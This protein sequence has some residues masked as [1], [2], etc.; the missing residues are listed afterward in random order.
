MLLFIEEI[1]LE[2]MLLMESNKDDTILISIKITLS[3]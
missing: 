1:K 2:K 3:F